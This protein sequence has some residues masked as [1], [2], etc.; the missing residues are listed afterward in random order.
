METDLALRILFAVADGELSVRDV[1]V[2]VARYESP[3]AGCKT[4][5]KQTGIPVSSVRRSFRR[6]QTVA[7]WTP[8][9]A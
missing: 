6:L 8:F 7:K 1:R 5:S 2:L 3:D 4:I 9:A